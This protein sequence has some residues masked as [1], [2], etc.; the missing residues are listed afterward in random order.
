MSRP[1]LRVVGKPRTPT[2]V[3]ELLAAVGSGIATMREI[4]RLWD[5]LLDRAGALDEIR[6]LTPAEVSAALEAQRRALRGRS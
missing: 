3:S 2:E 6:A 1:A 4:I 5:D